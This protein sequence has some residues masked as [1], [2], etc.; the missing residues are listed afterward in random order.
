MSYK[1]R[2]ACLSF[3]CACAIMLDF[4]IAHAQSLSGVDAIV[5]KGKKNFGG[6]MSV[7]V[8]KDTIV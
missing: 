8:W 1:T 4:Q 7:M 5:E 6:K 3:I 2:Y